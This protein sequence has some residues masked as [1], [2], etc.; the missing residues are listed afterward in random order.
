MKLKYDFVITPMGEESI[1][2]PVGELADEFHGMIRMNDSAA[3]ILELL[4]EDTTEEAVVQALC[5]EY[6]SP[7]AE[8]RQFVAAFLKQLRRE[9]VL[10]NG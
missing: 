8:I 4:K 2:V 3:A 6:D 9:G 1:A 5:R 10:D 7:A